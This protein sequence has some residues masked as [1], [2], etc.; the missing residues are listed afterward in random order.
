MSTEKTMHTKLT[1]LLHNYNPGLKAEEIAS[2]LIKN[3]VLV[4]PCK[5]GDEVW[6][7]PRYNGNPM[8]FVEPDRVQMIGLTSRGFHIKARNRHDHNKLHMLGKTAFLSKEDAEKSLEENV[9]D[10]KER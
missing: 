5:V 4:A 8:G 2:Y 1:E 10:N 3:N 9:K 7:T 6:L